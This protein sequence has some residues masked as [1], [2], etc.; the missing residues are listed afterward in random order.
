ML[1]T[2]KWALR[3]VLGTL[4]VGFLTSCASLE[5]PQKVGR[6]FQR[7]CERTQRSLGNWWQDLWGG[8]KKKTSKT[9][10]GRKRKTRTKPSPKP[11][12]QPTP[13]PNSQFEILTHE[14]VGA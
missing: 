12:P 9:H 2:R 7:A 13:A 8:K 3:I 14:Y 5:S 4:I 1:W 6:D 11:T 10:R